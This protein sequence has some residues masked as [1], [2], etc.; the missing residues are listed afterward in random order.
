MPD[1]F[2]KVKQGI[3]KGVNMVSV[4]SKEVVEAGKLKSQI[5]GLTEQL[6]QSFPELGSIVY[7]M[8]VNGQFDEEI[9]KTKCETIAA[10][11]NEI[12]LKED[13]LKQNRLKA[14]EA[15]GKLFCT[16]CQAELDPEAKFC[17]QCGTPVETKPETTS[18][19]P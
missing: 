12:K 13:E 19:T 1:F 11:E 3:D 8:F 4:K 17:G 18:T 14:Q 15:L 6:K 7:G 10:L 9:F 2:D 5:N 16:N